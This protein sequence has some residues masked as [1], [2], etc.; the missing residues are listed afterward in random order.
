MRRYQFRA[1][2]WPTLAAIAGIAATLALG[3]WQLGRGHEKAVLA[4]RVEAASHDAPIGLSGTEVRADDV[5]WRRVEVRGTFEPKYGVLI[6]NRIVRGTV[7]YYVVMPLK[8]ADSERY[9]LVNRGWVAGTGSR[10]TLPQV[11]TPAQSLRIVGLATVPSK[12]F[13][14]LSSKTVEGNVWENLTLERYRAAVPIAL[15][16]VV[17]QQESEVGDGLVREWSAPDLGIDRHYAYAFQWFVMAAAILII[18]VA[19]NVKRSGQ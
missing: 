19:V 13:L 4:E 5:V 17:I 9:V 10:S 14:E 3:N 1:S 8:I 16:P 18:Y 15:Q 2:L 6:D 11:T 12:R 7:G